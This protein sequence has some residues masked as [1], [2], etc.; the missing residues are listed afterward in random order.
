MQW[1]GRINSEIGLS[2]RGRN[3]L[4]IYKLIKTRFAA[5]NYCKLILPPR[6]RTAFNKFRCGVAP[7][8]IEPGRYEGSAED[9]Q[10]C[11]FCNILENEIHAI[12][13]CRVYEDRRDTL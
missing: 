8:R 11:P 7:L 10:L 12:I 3:K 2:G 9:L 4:R 5:E 6:H 13:N 1:S